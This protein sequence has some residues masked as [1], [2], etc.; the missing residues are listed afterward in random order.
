MHRN[1]YITEEQ[2]I[3]AQKEGL[4]LSTKPRIYSYNKAPYYI[5]FVLSELKNIGFE[6]Q[7]ISQGGLKIYTTLDYKSQNVAQQTASQSLIKAGLTR[8]ANFKYSFKLFDL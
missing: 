1:K 2:M 7:E 4:K 8:I 6:E 3:A 5:D